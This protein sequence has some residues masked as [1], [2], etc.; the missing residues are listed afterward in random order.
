MRIAID[1]HMVGTRETG[2]ETYVVNLIKALGKIDPDNEYVLLSD[3]PSLLPAELSAPPNFSAVQVLPAT[4]LIRIPVSMPYIA[5]R[6]RYDLLHVNYVAPPVSPVPTVVTIHDISYEFVPEFFSPRDRW[7]LSALVPFSASRAA[8]II[9]V[10]EH[11]KR[12]IVKEYGVP[13]DKVVVTHEAAASRFR[14][15]PDA[16]QT[17]GIRDK[18][19]ISNSFILTVG[20]LQPRKNLGRLIE[21]FIQLRQRI[22]S[23]P[24]LVIVGQPSWRESD[25]YRLVHDRGLLD[26][27]VFTGYVPDD[28][29]PLLFSAATIFVYPSLYEGFGL[30][31]LE[32]MACGAPV[33]ASNVSSLPEVLGDGALLVDP[34]DVE[35]LAQAMLDLLTDPARLRAVAA[36]GLARS[37]TFTWENTAR[38]TLHAYQEVHAQRGKAP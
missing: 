3:D 35:G 34:Y 1:A 21:A 17:R 18:Y 19:G 25:V 30:P 32:A 13:S 5:W 7:L 10:S 31:P 9:A 33:I 37:R 14:P 27:V 15:I 26:Q 8:K 22:V 12:D 4:S 29:L 2:N 38:Q 28:D 36:R 23:E 24:Q 20:N 11:T 6:E 16:Q